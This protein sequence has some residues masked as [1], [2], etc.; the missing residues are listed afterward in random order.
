[1]TT[2]TSIRFY[3]PRQ[4]LLAWLAGYPL[5][6]LLGLASIAWTIIHFDLMCQ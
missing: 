4:N 2:A 1:M 5:G 3:K 6:I